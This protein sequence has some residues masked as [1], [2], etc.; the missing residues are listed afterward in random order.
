MVE[1]YLKYNFFQNNFRHRG[2]PIVKTIRYLFV[3]HAAIDKKKKRSKKTFLVFTSR[4]IFPVR[5]TH[6]RGSKVAGEVVHGS[7]KKVFEF[8]QR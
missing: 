6:V 5:T 8:R 2:T 1:I 7:K 3:R 4:L